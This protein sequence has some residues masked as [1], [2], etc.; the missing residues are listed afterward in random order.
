MKP[1]RN[2]PQMIDDDD[3]DAKIGGQM[4]QQ[5]HIGVEAAG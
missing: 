5:P 3:S 4:P 2:N 1:G